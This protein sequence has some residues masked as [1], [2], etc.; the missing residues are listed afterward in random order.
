MALIRR[1]ND[2]LFERTQSENYGE[3][4]GKWRA[5]Q[6]DYNDQHLMFVPEWKA[7]YLEKHGKLARVGYFQHVAI[8][9]PTVFT[10]ARAAKAAAD[11][12]GEF[13][14]N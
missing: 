3:L 1:L 7:L 14:A 12:K 2:T 6:V 5:T 8:D 9:E 11:S 13:L 4:R 10:R